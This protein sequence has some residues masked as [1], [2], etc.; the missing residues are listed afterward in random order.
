MHPSRSTPQRSTLEFD[1]IDIAVAVVFRRSDGNRHEIL[2]ALRTHDVPRANLWEFPGGKVEPNEAF[3]HA[4]QREAR[5]ELGI[6]LAG[7]TYFASVHDEDPS[8]PREQ[9]ITL[10]AVAFDVS[11]YTLAPRALA[12]REVRWVGLDEVESLQWPR[13][14][15]AIFSA[16]RTWLAHTDRT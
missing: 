5:E 7:G 15:A 4:A 10:H 3:V 12:S 11:A 16:F 13:A 1:S 2:A 14:N 8:Q 9:V 6:E